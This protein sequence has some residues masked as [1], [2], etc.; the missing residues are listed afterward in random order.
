MIDFDKILDGVENKDEIVKNLK[1]EIGKEFVARSDFNDKNDELKKVQKMIDERDEQLKK[2][3]ELEGDKNTLKAEMEKLKKANDDATKK[4]AEELKELRLNTA[5]E[6]KLKEHF[7][8][9]TV[10]FI[11][12][13]IKKENLTLTDEGKVVGLDEEIEPLKESRKSFLK[14]EEEKK[15]P[16]FIAGG[17]GSAPPSMTRE[18]IEKINDPVERQK[19]IAEN[20]NLFK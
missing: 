14:T 19:K 6:S 8:D 18:D 13:L 15:N 17:S 10:D 11:K 3:S 9:D 5:M 1:A 2:L 20:I 7:R 16:R 12:T 4:H